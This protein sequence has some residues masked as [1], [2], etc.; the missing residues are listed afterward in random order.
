MT[1]LTD[2]LT[3][4][5]GADKSPQYFE[6]V[7]KIMEGYR[8]RIPAH[9]AS[10]TERDSILI[11]Y[12]DQVQTPGEKPLQ[13]L[14][15]FCRQNLAGVVN[16]IHIL[17]F[18]PWTSDDGFSVVDYRKVDPDLGAW[19]DISSMQSHFRLM[20]D[21]VI[22]HIS[23]QS[24][25][26]KSFLND[27]LHYRDYFVVVDG[28][29]DLSQVVRPRALPLLTT[30]K[31]PS[32]EKRVWTTFSED[33]IDLNF[34]NPEV[35]L[36]ILD[37]LLMYVEQG[38]TFIRLDAI[39]YLWKEIGTSCIHLPQTH[40]VIQFLR[41]AM[42]DLAPHVYLITETNV[43]H[44]DN[45]SYFGDGSNEAQLVYN[46]ALPPLTLHTFRTGDARILSEWAKTL[47]L[48]SE[49]V[50]FFNFLASHDGIGLNPARGILPP[51]DIDALVEKTL[52]HGGL[53][54]YK[55][56]SD[57]TQS[58]YEMNIN[59]FDALSNPQ[60]VLQSTLPSPSS[61]EGQPPRTAAEAESLDLQVNRFIAAHAIMLSLVG[62][63]GI[64][65]HSL[66]GSRGWMDGVKQTGRNR[67]IN[68][69]KCDLTSLQRELADPQSLRARVFVRFYQLLSARSN[70]P[71][72]DPHGTQKILD[73]HPS[74]FALERFSPDRAA[75]VLC[76]HN[77]SQQKITL[78]TPYESGTD[79]FTNQPMDVSQISLDSYQILW[80]KL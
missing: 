47:T 74:I 67:T 57:G 3:F 42:N 38:A 65:F 5:Y 6:R 43:P 12:G 11:T 79:L 30:F 14:S 19:V 54:S 15:V 72:F 32:G 39:A 27:D 70:S 29:P 80:I 71:A 17:P 44:M 35:L 52:E 63:P 40:S 64:Y 16:G 68:R 60:N 49:H 2:H 62:V 59:Y 46:F 41:A 61:A 78:S 20:F 58:P 26:F 69:E 76:L 48:P 28:S 24:D 13:T 10:L 77:V 4:L 21:G 66:F 1:N 18:Y 50:T 22:N 9:D 7:Q 33:Q 55:H 23:S 53:V 45:I 73:L 56:N 51:A 8:G 34:Q 36:E 31:T 25:W 37:V 75:R